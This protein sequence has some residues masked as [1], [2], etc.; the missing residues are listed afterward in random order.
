MTIPPV[1]DRIRDLPPYL[2]AEIDRIKTELRRKGVDVI[3][4]SIGDPDLPTPEVIVERLAE[5]AH[6]ASL[7][8]YPPYQG[9]ARFRKTV[10]LWYEDRFGVKLD[11][12]P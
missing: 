2:F 1:A 10:A 8:R 7:H 5:A 9:S 11:W 12:T 6:D 3:D 4:L